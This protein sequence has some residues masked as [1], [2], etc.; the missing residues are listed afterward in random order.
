VI[1]VIWKHKNFASNAA[2]LR[3]GAL[4]FL[5]KQPIASP[6]HGDSAPDLLST[7][8]QFPAMPLTTFI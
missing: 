1:A 5:S 6:D 3:N 8:T 4:P 2:R 7:S